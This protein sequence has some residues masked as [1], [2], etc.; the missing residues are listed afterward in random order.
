L[1][2]PNKRLH[3]P[4]RQGAGVSALVCYRFW[5]RFSHLAV[6][7]GAG[8]PRS[9]RCAPESAPRV[10]TGLDSTLAGA[11]AMTMS[12]CPDCC[13]DPKGST[14]GANCSEMLG[15][16]KVVRSFSGEAEI[17]VLLDVHDAMLKECA[18]GNVSFDKFL[19]Q[20]DTFPMRCPMDGHE[21]DEG[22]KEMLAK[23]A[24]RIA[25][26]FRVWD[27]ILTWL[28]SDENAS[29]PEYIAV[30]RFGSEEGLRRLRRIV[31][32]EFGNSSTWRT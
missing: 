8:E 13:M 25:V 11:P 6:S 24:D 1:A 29:K 30:G 20:Y 17:T 12:C 16:G 15:E 7:C 4:P 32:E 26:H 19:E 28:C 14:T 10:L 3:P 31:A 2:P 27:E 5:L 9:V 22:E 23:Y 18:L 21:S